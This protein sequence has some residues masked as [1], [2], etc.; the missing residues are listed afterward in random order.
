MGAKEKKSREVW[1]TVTPVGSASMERGDLVCL[2]ASHMNTLGRWERIM[3]MLVLWKEQTWQVPLMVNMSFE[4]GVEGEISLAE[5]EGLTTIR[6]ARRIRLPGLALA[7]QFGRHIV[8]PSTTSQF[9]H[10]KALANLNWGV[11]TWVMFT[12]DDEVRAEAYATM[13][14]NARGGG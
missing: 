2:C 7:S 6:Q 13:L 9:E 4:E 12:D 5:M 14:Q 11:A 10:S 3:Q 1:K 8:P